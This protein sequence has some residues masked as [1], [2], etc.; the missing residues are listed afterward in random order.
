MDILFVRSGVG[1]QL[2]LLEGQLTAPYRVPARRGDA[3][4]CKFAPASS[5]P[6]LVGIFKK[7]KKLLLFRTQ[8][9][10]FN[11]TLYINIDNVILVFKI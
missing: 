2:N 6:K 5:Q 9:F 3:V 4:T 1:A 8:N 7:K 10:C 11:E